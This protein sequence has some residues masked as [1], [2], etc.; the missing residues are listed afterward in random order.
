MAKPVP[1]SLSYCLQ[2]APGKNT[3]ECRIAALIAQRSSS[4]FLA[5][6]EVAENPRAAGISG[7]DALCQNLVATW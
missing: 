3:T 7:V 4:Q 2:V 1:G 6:I 5:V